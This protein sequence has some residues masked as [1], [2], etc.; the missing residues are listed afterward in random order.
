VG[1]GINVT[2][3]AA[4]YAEIADT[5]ASLEDGSGKGGLRLKLV[6]SLLTELD[7]LYRQLPNGKGIF[8]DWRDRLVTL[9][10]QVKATS[11]GQITEGVA[12]AVDEDGAL[13]IRGAE[14]TLTRVVAGDVTL[15]GK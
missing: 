7:I 10:K 13:L 6:Q 2:L 4:D 8:E 3:N 11:G 12:E 14:G 15:Q 9:G 5:A 1:I